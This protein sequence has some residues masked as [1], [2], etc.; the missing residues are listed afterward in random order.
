MDFNEKVGPQ[1]SVI[2]G[3]EPKALRSKETAKEAPPTNKV[4]FNV[5]FFG[6]CE[7]TQTDLSA[8]LFIFAKEP[9]KAK[10][11][12]FIQQDV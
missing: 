8:D 1:L 10:L 11:H 6:K 5:S 12:F 2:L 3:L 7:Q 9:L 4:C